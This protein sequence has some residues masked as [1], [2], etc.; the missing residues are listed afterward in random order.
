MILFNSFFTKWQ[1]SPRYRLAVVMLLCILIYLFMSPFDVYAQTQGENNFAVLDRIDKVFQPYQFSWGDKIRVYAERLFW[2]LAS[3][4][5]AW[6]GVLYVLEKNEIGEIAV[7]LTKKMLTLGF[8]YSILKFSGSWIPAIIQSFSDIGHAA[9]GA[10][11]ATPDGIAGMGYNLAIG[12][13]QSISDMGALKAI[14][15]V[16]PVTVV[17]IVIFLSYLFIA[18]QLLVTMIET[19]LAIG[20][21]VILLGFGGS[22]WTT[23][24]A[25]KYL[26]YA[27]ATGLKLMMIYLIVGLGQAISN[28]LVIVQSD[29]M[30]SCLKVLGV[31]LVFA[32]LAIQIPQIASAMMSGSPSLTAGGL[33]GAAITMGAAIAGGAA[34]SK[35]LASGGAQATG[36]AAAGA[37]GL[38]KALNSGLNLAGDM[39]KTGI[40]AAAHAAGA[41]A[42]QALGMAGQAIGSAITGVTGGFSG[43]VD[44]SAGGQISSSLE[45]QR[46]GSMSGAASPFG[47]ANAANSAPA[48]SGQGASSGPAPA[49]SSS[50]ASGA[51]SGS[52]SAS[53]SSSSASAPASGGS[54]PTG[55]TVSAAAG[56]G[57]APVPSSAASAAPAG[58]A[59]ASGSAN[60]LGPSVLPTSAGSGVENLGN[61]SNA[62]LSSGPGLTNVP[63]QGPLPVAGNPTSMSEKIQSLQGYVPQ[64]AA[65][66]GGGFNIQAGHTAD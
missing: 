32:Y 66:G 21:G 18:A 42:G 52:A 41:V 1:T 47:G 37:M 61:A 27:V 22:R 55:S 38:G 13:F 29:L 50:G 35:Q 62:A 59:G 20:A 14:A 58:A 11:V 45:N 48:G 40:G 9:G 28:D 30:A 16:F 31:A 43:A 53:G 8:F 23:D 19:Y 17:A 65:S 56:N 34:A 15:V 60:N 64:D 39:G 49:S 10:N 4:D 3:V 54:A 7:S 24:M 36:G 25:T 6:S 44:A 12:A 33:A 51:S 63:D 46:G 57:A 5:M 26:Q 2:M